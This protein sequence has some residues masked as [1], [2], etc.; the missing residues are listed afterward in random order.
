MYSQHRNCSSLTIAE[1]IQGE[2]IPREHLTAEYVKAVHVMNDRVRE[3]RGII[4]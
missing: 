3:K 4:N 1:L 2:W